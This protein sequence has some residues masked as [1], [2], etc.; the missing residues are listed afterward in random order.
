MQFKT[1]LHIVHY[2]NLMI[3]LLSLMVA[4][5]CYPKKICNKIGYKIF[6]AQKLSDKLMLFI[7]AVILNYKFHQFCVNL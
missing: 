2:A 4:L 5:K 3:D 1:T 6:K 7:L